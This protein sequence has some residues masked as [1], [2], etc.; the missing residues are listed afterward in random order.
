MKLSKGFVVFSLSLVIAALVGGCTQPGPSG[1][2]G[3]ERVREDYSVPAG[4]FIRETALCPEGKVV[5]GGGAQVVGDGT[6]DFKTVIRESVGGSVG[7]GSEERDLWLVAIQNDDT[8]G[9]TI[10]IYAICADAQ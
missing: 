4:G 1:I 3:Y 6:R 10:G 7:A 8:V 9:H 5:L 2:S